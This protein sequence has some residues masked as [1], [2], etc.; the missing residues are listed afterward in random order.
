[1]GHSIAVVYTDDTGTNLECKHVPWDRFM[2]VQ[3]DALVALIIMFWDQNPPDPP[4]KVIYSGHESYSI[5]RSPGRS[6]EIT[7]CDS[8]GP[9]GNSVARDIAL[10]D[11][12]V[13]SRQKIWPAKL[14]QAAMSGPVRFLAYDL[15]AP[16]YDAVM[17]AAQTLAESTPVES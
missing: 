2:E 15:D 16:N 6:L 11:D 4:N 14:F 17:A 12:G 13:G 10:H 8:Q 7:Q 1:M 9:D 5:R 3:N